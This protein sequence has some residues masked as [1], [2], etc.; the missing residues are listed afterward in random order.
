MN[1][2]IQKLQSMINAADNVAFFGGAGVSTESGIPDFRSAHGLY[3]AP[4]GRSYE[5]MLSIGYYNGFPDAFWRF[6]R[7]VMLYPQAKPNAA[8]K[9]LKRLEDQGRLKAIITQNIDGLHQAAGSRN[10]IELHGSVHRNRCEKCGRFYPLAEVLEGEGAP[11]CGGSDGHPCG[12]RIKPEVVLYGEALDGQ[13]LEEAV[14]A[15]EACELLIVGGTSLVVHPA[16]GLIQYRQPSTPIV[17]LN[18]DETPY[19]SMA[20][21]VIRD[22]LAQV[23]DEAIT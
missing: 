18:R 10:V 15:I 17:L 6:Y 7:S 19:D 21:L 20:S 11:R 5:E 14:R 2:D 4:G 9:A 22:N 16:A 23:L 12:G 3:N 8:H 13:V 1:A